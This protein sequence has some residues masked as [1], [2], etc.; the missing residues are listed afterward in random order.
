MI[1][2]GFVSPIT[3]G[4][5]APL[6]LPVIREDRA[7]SLSGVPPGHTVV[8]G[9]SG[10]WIHSGGPRPV[11]LDLVGLPGLHRTPPGRHPPGWVLRFHS[12]RAAIEPPTVVSDVR[13]GSP[14]RCAVDGLR[15]GPLDSAVPRVV[16]ALRTGAIDRV[17]AARLIGEESPRGAGVARLRS[18]WAAIESVL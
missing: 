3:P 9:L 8:S 13:I 6:D 17:E 1:R 14:A 4:F 5:A 16:T 10:L 12:G 11:F 7:L 18:A 2:D 15:W